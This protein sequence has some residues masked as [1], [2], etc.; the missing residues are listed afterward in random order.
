MD[1]RTIVYVIG[2]ICMVWVIY[3]VWA[4]QKRMSALNKVLWT[5]FAVIF[6][7]LTAI[8]YKFVRKK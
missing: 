7:I 5:V 4:V 2:I 3:D 8:I 6:N 1:W